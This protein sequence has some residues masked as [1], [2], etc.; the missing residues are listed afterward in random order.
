LHAGSKAS[1]LIT[2]AIYLACG[3]DMRVIAEGVE[4]EEQ[5]SLLRAAGCHELQG[6]LFGRAMPIGDLLRTDRSGAVIRARRRR[7]APKPGPENA[8]DALRL[9]ALGTA[10]ATAGM[11]GG[12]PAAM[13]TPLLATSSGQ[14]V[15]RY[16]QPVGST[17]TATISPSASHRPR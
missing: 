8:L 12:G 3:L 10:N 7:S 2:G 1:L 9:L 16:Q 5:A 6:F 11:A 15:D 14:A 17:S 4:T 13:R